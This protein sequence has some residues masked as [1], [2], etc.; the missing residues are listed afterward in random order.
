MAAEAI[1]VEAARVR[2]RCV[3]DVG[4]AHEGWAR[5][6]EVAEVKLAEGHE[7][8]EDGIV[9]WLWHGE[10]MPSTLASRRR[11]K[12]EYLGAIRVGNLGRRPRGEKS[13]L[14]HRST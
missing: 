6:G 13:D 9:S 3:G 2:I 10:P 7:R 12:T 11:T 5:K 14:H 1:G 8:V 4:F